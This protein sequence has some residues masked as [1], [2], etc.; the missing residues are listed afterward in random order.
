MTH[1][2]F[3]DQNPNTPIVAAWLNDVDGHVYS[4][5]P[6]APAT[7]VHP[8]TA[9]GYTA[10]GTGAVVR[11]VAS[12]LGESLSIR[13]YGA[14]GDGVT[15]DTAAIQAAQAQARILKKKVYAPAGVYAYSQ[16]LDLTQPGD[17]LYGDGK[18]YT[19]FKYTG[20]E[21]GVAVS[22]CYVADL[23]FLGTI[24]ANNGVV[25]GGDNGGYTL[26]S[27]VFFDRVDTTGYQR[28]GQVSAVSIPT[29]VGAGYNGTT[30]IIFSAPPSGVTATGSA[31]VSGGALVG[32][33]ITNRGSGYVTPPTIT[34]GGAGAGADIRAYIN[35]SG[36]C[37]RALVTGTFN[38]C[39][40]ARNWRGMLTTRGNLQTTLS[41]NDVLFSLTQGTLG[42]WN[43]G[44]GIELEG[45][46]SA[47]FTNCEMTTVGEESI[48]ITGKGVENVVFNNNYYEAPNLAK[49]GS[50]V[51]VTGTLTTDSP[52]NITFN[53][54]LIGFQ[55]VYPLPTV[56]G[57]PSA[58]QAMSEFIYNF[59]VA[60]NCVI[61]EPKW[62]SENY[63]YT[64]YAGAGAVSCAFES[65]S[66][67][68]VHNQALASRVQG[69][70]LL[71]KSRG[72]QIL[73]GQ[74]Y[75]PTGGFV[76]SL[77]STTPSVSGNALTYTTA[78]TVATVITDFLDAF[79]GQV[80]SVTFGDVNTS[81]SGANFHLKGAGAAGN[82]NGATIEFIRQASVWEETSRI[83]LAE[84]LYPGVLGGNAGIFVISTQNVPSIISVTLAGAINAVG[85]I[86]LNGTAN[87]TAIISDPSAIFSITTN[88]AGKV[89]CNFTSG[90]YRGFNNT[91]STLDIVVKVLM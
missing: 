47:V 26:S 56:N 59:D 8:A 35:S 15:D 88:A 50:V 82:L 6:V 77:N 43:G 32:V 20:A 65:S 83:Y 58:L 69:V 84:G 25:S 19:T 45:L 89:W 72:L 81:L 24:A 21:N 10:S 46:S 74:S 18:S 53:N 60:Y 33:I 39:N 78:N 23:T 87:T 80:L 27:M 28:Q 52:V 13:D 76:S 70:K 66:Y 44:P 73:Y 61:R 86:A 16:L 40:N 17:Y 5:A 67:G 68:S 85:I 11:T 42:Y 37:F 51:L 30:T 71:P 90:N 79:I 55:P 4:S 1:T 62:I 36:Y 75:S 31:L 38:Q 22:A 63:Y 91:G 29:V 12:K 3:V 48:K 41:F 2:V 14:V 49:R 7:A 54:D 64:I 57:Y 9:L 34:T